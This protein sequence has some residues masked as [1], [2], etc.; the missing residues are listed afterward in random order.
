DIDNDGDLDISVCG[1]WEANCYYNNGDETFSNA[2]GIVL[3]GVSNS[4]LAHGDFDNDGDLDLVIMGDDGSAPICKIFR[5]DTLPSNPIPDVPSN[6]TY[7]ISGKDLILKWN[8]V[9]SDNTDTLSISYNIMLGSSSGASDIIHPS[10]NPSGMLRFAS[11]GNAQTDTTF[12]MRNLAKGTY[13]WK[14]QSID[15]CF[16]G[17]AFS[18]EN[19][20]AYNS[21]CQAYSLT[22]HDVGGSATSLS[23]IRGNG[24]NCIVFVKEDAV[25]NAVPI[26]NSTYTASSDFGVGSEISGTGWYCVHKGTENSVHITGLNTF[27]SYTIQ[28]F[29]YSNTTGNEQYQTEISVNNSITIAT[30]L[31]T[32]IK[33]LGLESGESQISQCFWVDVDNDEDLDLFLMAQGR[34]YMYRN[35]GSETFSP[36]TITST[37]YETADFADIN[38]DGNI[39]MVLSNGSDIHFFTNDGTGNFTQLGISLTG[40]RYGSMDFGDYDNDG[41]LDLIITGDE[42]FSFQTVTKIYKNNGDETFTEAHNHGIIYVRYG[43]TDWADINQDNFLDIAISGISIEGSYIT[44]VFLNNKDGSF[45]ELCNIPEG[46]GEVEWGDFDNDGDYDLLFIG[47]GNNDVY[48]ND[49]MNVFSRLGG[50]DFLASLY[51][52]GHWGDYNND[53]Y[54]DIMVNGFQSGYEPHASIFKNLKNGTFELDSSCNLRA[55]GFSACSWGDFDNDG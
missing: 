33:N 19:S 27:S 5:N 52:N 12:V 16:K 8:P 37:S 49:G 11:M 39:D 28:V 9:T 10:S 38:N 22:S 31:F 23:W 54:L 43:S 18:A 15:N 25:D 55:V 47:N 34:K 6:L 3:P 53:G 24:E 29:E 35:L 1:S 44:K 51:G 7:E 42:G 30:G 36:I 2:S 4:D 20:F 48:Q 13:Y 46:I 45:S 40:F 32:E 41:D 17:S 21:D 14:V 26:D 50:I